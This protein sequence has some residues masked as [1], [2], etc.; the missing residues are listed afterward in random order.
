M[1]TAT[2]SSSDEQVVMLSPT[3]RLFHAPRFNCHIIAIM[4]CKTGIDP[5]VLKLGLEH[6]LIKHP[7]F[8]SK[9][10]VDGRKMKWN[11]TIVNLQDHIIVPKLDPNMES[12]DQFVEDYISHLTTIPMDLC[13]P[14]WEVHLLNLKTSDAEA[15]GVFR[16]HHSIGDG[17]SLMSLL[18][19]CTRKTSDPEAL[20]SIPE[21]RRAGSSTS[22]SSDGFCWFFL[23]IW[24]ILRLIWNS[25]V[26]MILFAATI[27][28]LEDTKTPLKGAFGVD[29]KPKRFVYRSVSMDDI[30]LIKNK[31]NITINDVILGITQAGLSR[32]LNREYG[33]NEKDGETKQNKIILPKS[34]LLRATVL[35]NLRPAVGIQT[36]ADLMGKESKV[37]W[38]WGN[39]IG[40]LVLPFTISLQ[41]DPL[42]YV[43]QAK[44]TIDRKKRS[45]E[46]F[47]TF[48]IA[49]LVLCTLGV[50]VGAA[51]AHRFLSNTTLAFSNVVGPV[52]EV[53]FYG[54]PL[55]FI[56]PS[57]Y[58]HPHALT[59][60]FQS[61]S[62]KMTIVLAV[63]VDVIPH[64][65][66]LCDDLEQSLKLIKDAVLDNGL[67]A[68]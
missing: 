40:Y 24:K 67:D 22:P 51:I 63:D 6:T 28:F 47:C 61:Y 68:A 64:P 25:L 18:L 16:I 48:Q 30:K 55:A 8:S 37:K 56:A 65:H 49:K 10:V 45:L 29:L 43:R 42:N 13:K 33:E 66:K 46:P 23:V 39:R 58:G 59:I 20:P 34:I 36:L 4:G 60:H 52:E 62:N 11:P 7:R 53:S 32:Y 44:A 3:A 2:G 5:I 21:Q 57:V 38:G 50:K 31:M 14:L 54:H 41:D 15:I 35:V 19:A 17:A 1:E 26:D 12:P 27:F 9:L